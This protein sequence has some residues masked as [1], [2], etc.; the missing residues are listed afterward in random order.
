MT[1]FE[2]PTIELGV[3]FACNPFDLAPS[4]T[5]LS[6]DLETL[7]ITRGRQTE[8]DQAQTGQS[9]AVLLDDTA[10][11]FND[12]SLSVYHG[13]IVPMLPLRVVITCDGVTYPKF[14]GWID[15]Q[16]GWVR[17]E[18]DPGFAR[19]RVPANDGFDALNVAGVY[20]NAG[21]G[22]GPTGDPGFSFSSETTGDRI[23]S[24][25]AQTNPTWPAAWENLDAGRETMQA[26]VDDGTATALSLIRDAEL[27]E[28]GFF[29][30][31][32]NG[33]ANF[34]D[35]TNLQTATSQATFCDSTNY[36]G[37]EVMFTSLTTRRT[38]LINDVRTTRN[39]GTE[40]RALDQASKDQNLDRVQSYATQHTDDAHALLFSKWKMQQSKDS[41]EVIESITLVPG[42]DLD[43][44]V[45]VL[46]RDLGDRITVTRTPAGASV[47]VTADYS[48]QQIALNIGPGATAS[49]TWR[50]AAAAQTT[51]W[52]A[53]T[54]GASEAGTTTRAGY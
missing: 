40:Q 33:Y 48:I 15:P 39:G 25:L 31:D 38:T 49:C 32:G 51:L 50:L 47:P 24:V 11:Y 54:V 23:A 9:V 36:T 1:A 13:L 7:S 29:F 42:M 46:E 20:E 26:H 35:R 37:S 44:W 41:Y 52:R 12:N 14:Y 16:D 10:A 53:G 34:R 5:D 28:P 4:F 45:Q 19:V 30:F 2:F 22:G 21:G 43:T 8:N 18:S 17:Q 6:A 3:A 27:T